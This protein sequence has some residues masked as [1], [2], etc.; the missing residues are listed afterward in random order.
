MLTSITPTSPAN[1]NSPSVVGTAEAGSTVKLYTDAACSEMVASGTA[2]QLSSPGIAITVSD[3]TMTAFY[4]SAT[5]AAGNVSMCSLPISYVEDSTPPATPTLVDTLPLSPSRSLTPK[6]RGTVEAKAQVIVY[7]TSDCSGTALGMGAADTAGAFSIDIAVTPASTTQI[8]AVAKDAAGNTSGCTGF[9]LTYIHNANALSA[10]TITSSTPASPSKS[11][12]MPTLAGM[13][14]ANVT[15]RIYTDALCS[16]AMAGSAPSSGTGTF[17]VPVTVSPNTTTTF[18]AQAFDSAVGQLSACSSSTLVYT[19]DSIAPAPPS[20]TGSSPASPSNSLMP[21]IT[22]SAE[23]G[24]T[25][26]LYSDSGCTSAI[27]GGTGASINGA[28]AIQVSTSGSATYY[29]TSTDAAG[30]VSTCSGS[31]YNFIYDAAAPSPPSLSGTSP[32]SPSAANNTPIVIGTAENNS[33]VRVYRTNNCTGAEAG[34]GLATPGFGIS[35]TVPSNSITM[36]S[37]TATDAAGNTSACS[38]M[39]TY[40]HDSIAPAAPMLTATLP[41]SPANMNSPAITGMTE[42]MA[43]VQLYTDATCTTAVGTAVTASSGGAFSVTTS[44]TD[45]S[46]TTYYAKATDAAGNISGCSAGLSY[47]EDSVAPGQPSLNALPPS[48]S[49]TMPTLTGTA[50]AS[51]TVYIYASASCGGTAVAMGAVT[52]SGSYSIPVTVTANT[53]TPFSAKAVDAANNGSACSASIT[54]V[55]DNVVPVKPTGLASSPISPAA[56]TSPSITGAAEAGSTV[57]LYTNN[58]CSTAVIGTTTSSGT[59]S[60]SIP[61]TVGAGSTTTFYA[62]ATDSAN[63]TSACSTDLV[64]Y[65]QDSGPPN[66]PTALA[67]VPGSPANNTMPSVTGNAEAASTVKLY[68]A[69]GCTVASFAAMGTTS[70]LGSFS[71]PVS[72]TANTTTTFYATATDGAGNTSTCTT[73]GVSYV[74]DSVPP[75]TPA[76]LT[77]TPPSPANYNTPKIHGTTE[78]QASVVAYK[79]SGC[80]MTAGSSTAAAD[81]QFDVTVTV[82]DNTT[83]TFYVRATDAAGNSSPCTSTASITYVED[84]TAVSP[85]VLTAT[86]PMSPSNASTTP[87]VTG[88]AGAGFTIRLF[89]DAQCAGA[90][91]GTGTA[92]GGAFSIMVSVTANTTTTFYGTANNGVTT[93]ACSSG[94]VY[95][96]DNIAPTAPSALVTSPASPA[97]N[98]TPV[99]RGNAEA[100][101]TVQLFTTSNCS[102]AIVGTGTSSG[103][104][105]VTV[106]AGVIVDNT[107]TTFYAKAIDAANNASGCSTGVAY[108]EDS[109]GPGTPGITGTSP[110]SPANANNP[111]VNGT[112]EVGASVALYTTAGCTGVPIA[113]TT[114]VAPGSF[115][116][117][118]SVADNSTTSLYVKATDAANN[119]S[120]CSTAA[121]NYVEDSAAPGIPTLSTINPAGPSS[122]NTTVIGGSTTESGATIRLFDNGSCTGTPIGTGTSGTG[123]AFSVTATVG[124]D[125]T[126]TI[127]ANARDVAGNTSSCST[128]SQVYVE[129][130]TPP[131]PPKGLAV[132]PKSPANDNQPTIYGVGEAGA[133]VNIYTDTNCSSVVAGTEAVDANGEFKIQVLAGI[134]ADDTTHVFYANT[135]DA[136]G[137]VSSCS[138]E[139]VEYIEDSTAAAPLLSSTTPQSPSSTSTT[140]TINGSA[141]ASSTVSLYTNSTCTSAVAG[142]GGVNGVGTF[143]IS[144]TAVAANTSTTYWGKIVDP[145]GN[146]SACSTSNVTFISDQQA[147]TFAGVIKAVASSYDRILVQWTTA[148]DSFTTAAN[149]RYEL[150]WGTTPR[151]CDTWTTKLTITGTTSRLVTG[152]S[153]GTRYW[154]QARA[155]DQAGNTGIPTPQAEVSDRTWSTGSTAQITTGYN[156]ACALAAEGTVQCWGYGGNGNLGNGSSVD[157]LVPVTVTGMVDV[158]SVSAGGSQSIGTSTA[159]AVQS[160]GAVFCWGYGGNGNLGNGGGGSSSTPVQVLTAASTPLT[161]AVSVAVGGGHACAVISDGTMRCWGRGAEGQ[162]GDGAGTQ[163][164]YATLVAGSI[165]NFASVDAGAYHTCAVLAD[166]TARCWG[167]GTFGQLGNGSTTGQLSPVGV[168]LSGT[169]RAK[170]IDVGDYHSCA[171]I[172][173]GTVRCWGANTTGQLGNNTTTNSSMPVVVLSGGVAMTNVSSIAAGGAFV[174]SSVEGTTC[175][176]LAS[177]GAR[178]WG[179]NG[180]GQLGN[181]TN[182]NQSQAVAVSSISNVARVSVGADFACSL[183][184]TGTMTC[185]GDGSNGRLGTGTTA[186]QTTPVA[187]SNLYASEGVT[188]MAGT[189]ASECARFSNG[190]VRCWGYNN[191]G[192]LGIGTT[193]STPYPELAVMQTNTTL[194]NLTSVAMT[195]THACATRADGSV[196][197][198][199]Y[200]AYGQLGDASTANSTQAVTVAG[201]SNAIAVATGWN[202]SCALIADGTI[203]CWGYNGYG[204]LGNGTTTDSFTPVTVSG[205]SNA[206]AVSAQSYSTCAT[207]GDG[208]AKCW[209]YNSYG[210]VGDMTTTS[211]TSPATVTGISN[212]LSISGGMHHACSVIAGGGA[213][214]WGLGDQGQMGNGMVGTTNSVPV[215]VSGTGYVRLSAGWHTACAIKADGRSYCWGQNSNGQVGNGNVN[216]PVTTP[217]TTSGIDTV[218]RTTAGTHS[219]A[220]HSDGTIEA[221]GDGSIGQCGDGNGGSHNNLTP[222]WVLYV[223]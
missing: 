178:C 151:A 75:T 162:L 28:F 24:S 13:A 119:A 108:V 43:R 63:N 49:S 111:F 105:N 201:L 195:Y 168:L 222:L 124:N 203:K 154:F 137:N 164:N 78:A 18:Y 80:T 171:L 68:K 142:S 166:G 150:C 149:M 92:T 110:G 183:G 115:S 114:A 167:Q 158:V 22:G 193:V 98:N 15:V 91:A 25:V 71:I 29:A 177:G 67:T 90:Q 50:E 155:V 132:E 188:T 51:T 116:V 93:S 62:T 211:K 85:P 96:H 136:A 33:T 173:N 99:V 12:L 180:F 220:L 94:L 104:F 208:T 205:I 73:S 160:N 174:G 8:S 40:V 34:S 21:T 172:V 60:F 179:Y 100:G 135:T 144:V 66:P 120:A 1:N 181:G 218:Y 127:F 38:G 97:N 26:T 2:D 209:G 45:N 123:G 27:V 118:I 48:N 56:S 74:H 165:T 212:A 54:Y 77:T 88:T 11:S 169:D 7:A 163:R 6:V 199:G 200:N 53:S 61:V 89:T 152:L 159:C 182:T 126:T 146:T 69:A 197:C 214:C 4:A 31:G 198:W 79:D 131:D 64:T 70:G 125:T 86:N 175:A 122:Q 130:S 5:D 16:S 42:A 148:T 35:I 102:G 157:S 221:W 9:G 19:H 95:V 121:V 46:S 107:T 147:P 217:T 81:G 84:S 187:V 41:G 216:S 153:T 3:D 55:H 59:G 170:A 23:G 213:K 76:G 138:Q 161:N 17:S 32:T 72:V 207:L 194:T 206:V 30:N 44:V 204:A 196:V 36:L 190:R 103:T 10:P 113:T 133:T 202:H 186:S 185:W 101:S 82:V 215:A 47:T 58:T 192:Q 139:S 37:A 109:A 39:L 223:P 128:T 57:R 191:A 140:P 20:V 117:Q 14:E 112:A 52:G 176:T 134:I 129:D 106:N 184:A 83:T 145:A 141:E 210:N 87:T 156:F 143:S 189:Y 219:S 65:I